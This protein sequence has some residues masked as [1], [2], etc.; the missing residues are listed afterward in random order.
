MNTKWYTQVIEV[1]FNV[2]QFTLHLIVFQQVISFKNKLI[3]LLKIIMNGWVC[4]LSR[5]C[6]LKFMVFAYTFCYIIF[7]VADKTEIMM[8]S[9]GNISCMQIL[10]TSKCCLISIM[11]Q[12]GLFFDIIKNTI[13]IDTIFPFNV[14]VCVYI[15]T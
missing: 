11:I 5:I 1:T 12:T 4:L 2:L 15:L 8:L 10:T 6:L 7:L 3:E 13:H 14:C 9:A